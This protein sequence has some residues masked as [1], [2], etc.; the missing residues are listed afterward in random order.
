MSPGIPAQ[1]SIVPLNRKDSIYSARQLRRVVNNRVPG[2]RKPCCLRCAQHASP[3][4]RDI[5]FAVEG[6]VLLFQLL[7]NLLEQV[8]V[9]LWIADS[10]YLDI[11]AV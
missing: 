11:G 9:I 3:V 7:G 2:S 10:R 8:F 4:L 5:V 1:Q 6:Q